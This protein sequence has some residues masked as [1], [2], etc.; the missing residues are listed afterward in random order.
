MKAIYAVLTVRNCLLGH[1]ATLLFPFPSPHVFSKVREFD[2]FN[3]FLFSIRF[4][5]SLNFFFIFIGGEHSYFYKMGKIMKTGKVVLVLA[6]KYAGRKAVI[7]KVSVEPVYQRLSS[8]TVIFKIIFRTT[9]KA[10]MIKVTD[11]H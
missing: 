1:S 8:F 6:G 11:M 3:F 9:M 5:K 4:S 10:R 2:C 7:I